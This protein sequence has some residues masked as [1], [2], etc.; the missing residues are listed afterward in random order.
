MSEANPLHALRTTGKK[1][2][3]VI[4]SEFARVNKW[5][6]SNTVGI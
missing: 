2:H 1:L 5:Q 6:D 3:T 4:T